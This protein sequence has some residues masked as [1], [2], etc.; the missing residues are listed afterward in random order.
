VEEYEG[1]KKLNAET[2]KYCIENKNKLREKLLK[3][4]EEPIEEFD[5]DVANIMEGFNL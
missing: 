3:I 5:I 2:L 1:F 4:N